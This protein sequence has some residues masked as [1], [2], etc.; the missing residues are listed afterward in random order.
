MKYTDRVDGFQI[1]DI[2]WLVPPNNTH[3]LRFDVVK[4]YEHQPEEQI[5]YR[6]GEK[7]IVSENCYS[8]G[9]LGYNG[10]EGCFDFKSV[11]MRWLASHPT[12]AAEDMI[13]DFSEKMLG[14]IQQNVDVENGG[15]VNYGLL[16]WIHREFS[17]SAGRDKPD[18]TDW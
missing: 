12:K 5:N 6:T 15:V 9:T 11:G 4:W 3:P 10:K 17:G 2:S 16:P 14:W 8:V 18:D 7:R 13:L 1:C